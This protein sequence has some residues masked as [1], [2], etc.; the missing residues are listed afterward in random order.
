MH[1]GGILTHC[2]GII[3]HCRGMLPH[4]RGILLHCRGMLPH[5]RGILP[6]CRGMARLPEGV[7][8]AQLKPKP[9]RETCL[10]IPWHVCSNP[11]PEG[12]SSTV[13]THKTKTC[14]ARKTAYRGFF[15][16]RYFNSSGKL[17]PTP[18]S[19]KNFP[20]VACRQSLTGR[21]LKWQVSGKF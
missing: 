16:R 3:M 17:V 19:E 13:N 11:L 18:T 10:M 7:S 21:C 2:G 4:S 14:C 20:T 9:T 1:C 6:R 5:C 12:A 15:A 8:R